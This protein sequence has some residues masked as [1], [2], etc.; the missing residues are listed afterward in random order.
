[1]C[2]VGQNGRSPPPNYY[3]PYDNTTPPNTQV[4]PS[5]PAVIISGTMET[6]PEETQENEK[7]LCH[8]EETKSLPV[9]AE[10]ELP[11]GTTEPYEV[12]DEEAHLLC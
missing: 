1:M 2:A 11:R 3:A 8:K 10:Q 12:E 4:T 5:E 7:L 9:E 6:T